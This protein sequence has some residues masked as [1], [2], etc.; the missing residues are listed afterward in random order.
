MT[1][2][3]RNGELDDSLLTLSAPLAA[4]DRVIDAEKACEQI[5][6]FY[7]EVRHV[8][9]RRARGKGGHCSAILR[10]GRRPSGASLN[11]RRD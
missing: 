2:D 4:T 11:R 9:L 3:P 10:R 8:R 6:L 1:G 5:H 7:R